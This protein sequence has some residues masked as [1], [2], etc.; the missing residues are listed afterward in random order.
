MFV[1]HFFK[2]YDNHD[3]DCHEDDYKD[4][5]VDD[6]GGHMSNDGEDEIFAPGER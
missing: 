5:I 4:A 6:V 2:H 1:E 3:V